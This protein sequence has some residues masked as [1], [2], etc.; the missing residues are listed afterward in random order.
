MTKKLFALG[1]LIAAIAMIP[2]QALAVTGSAYPSI[3]LQNQFGEKSI[4]SILGGSA[5]LDCV[6]TV[7]STDSAGKGITNLVGPL[8]GSVYMHTSQTPSS[9]NPNPAAGYIVVNL[10]SPYFEFNSFSM[11]SKS[12]PAPTPTNVSS[13]VV[14]GNPYVIY[15]VGT[16]TATQWEAIGLPAGIVPAVGAGFIASGSTIT[17]GTGAVEPP[18]TVAGGVAAIDRIGNGAAGLSA[19]AGAQIILRVA[20]PTSSSVTTLVAAAPFDGT[21][22]GLHFILRPLSSQLK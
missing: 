20:A 6:F 5:G 19:S 17:S 21:V 16:T 7:A 18:G 8:C 14:L 9:G 3:V 11:S 10:T 13:G 12:I 4:N 1:M 2:A 22:I 15:S